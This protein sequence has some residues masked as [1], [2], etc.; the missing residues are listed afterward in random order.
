MS[1]IYKGIALPWGITVRSVFDPKDD[2]D[3]LRSSI[4]WI[5]MTRLGERVMLPEFGSSV[6]DLVFEPN[7][8]ISASTVAQQVRA[9]ISRW[10]DRVQ[11]R[12][13]KV[14][15]S[16]NTMHCTLTYSDKLSNLSN[17]YETVEFEIIPSAF[18]G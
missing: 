1:D 9:A 15:G 18:T 14:S 5:I 11:F 13:F 7:D 12:D 2:K 17:S 16:D 4:L 3:I 8:A 10:D 6:P